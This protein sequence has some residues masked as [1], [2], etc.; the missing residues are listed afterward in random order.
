VVKFTL[1][2]PIAH[3]GYSPALLTADGMR[4]VVV[5]AE[6][7]GFDSIAFTEHPAPSQKW[8]AGG[9]HESFDPLTALA[10]CAGVTSTIFLQTYLLVLPYRNPFLAAKQAATLHVMSGGRVILSVGAGYLRSE[11]LAL[12]VEFEERNALFDEALEVMRRSWSEDDVVYEGL[13]FKALGQTQRPRPPEP[14]P[15]IWIGGNGKVAR[16]RAARH[17]SG[18]TPLLIAP[19]MAKT[20]RTAP[21]LTAEDLAR[22]V[23]DLRELAAAAGRDAGQLDVQVEWRESS[24]ITARPDHILERVEELTVAGATFMVV[25]PPGDDLEQT[26]E[27]IAAYGESVIA[28]A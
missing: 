24:S 12:G 27:L 6:T 2:Y 20:T 7:A 16:R 8:M 28:V 11:F 21:L 13:H 4:K 19:E 5:A 1:Q 17:G 15:T 23:E 14:G 18:W 9:G 10:L 22:A 25:D 3:A 26:A